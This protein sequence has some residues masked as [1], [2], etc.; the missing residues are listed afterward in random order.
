VCP[1]RSHGD[2]G[3]GDV[4]GAFARGVQQILHRRNLHETVAKMELVRDPAPQ[5]DADALPVSIWLL[6]R[7][8]WGL[9]GR[10]DDFA[11]RW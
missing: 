9:F 6:H 7:E 10:H 2:S 5:I 4:G 3:N 8:W 1:S 11:V